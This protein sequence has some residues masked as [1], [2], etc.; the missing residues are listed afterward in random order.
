[1]FLLKKLLSAWLLPPL[2]LLVVALTALLFFRRKKFGILIGAGSLAL[3]LG[4][5]LPIVADNLSRTLEGVPITK[6]ELQ[7]AEAIVVLGCGVYYG[8]PEYGGDTVS[9]Y[10]LERLRYAAK[11][12]RESK[13]PVLVTGGRVYG[14]RPEGELMK[15][16]LESEFA[17]PVRWVES[18]SRDTAENAMLSAVT[19]KQEGIARSALVTHAWHM[20]RAVVEFT[21]QGLLVSP[22][23]TG[24]AAQGAT[25]FESLL[26]SAGAFERSANAIREWVGI[27]VQKVSA[28]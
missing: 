15:R 21:K 12:A 24:F 8:A 23:P 4:M 14:G 19:L 3:A 26:P 7:R 20:P 5:S 9:R 16:A 18:Q 25:L 2:G 28:K 6:E 13:L 22:A 11:L 1:M 17:V 10:S 27:A